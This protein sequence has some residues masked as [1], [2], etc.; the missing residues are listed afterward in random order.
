[1]SFLALV[2]LFTL[3]IFKI[4]LGTPNLVHLSSTAIKTIIY[5]KTWQKSSLGPFSVKKA[6]IS[7]FGL[8]R[9]ENAQNA[10]KNENN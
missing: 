4:E 10:P 3:K 1:M 2:G 6:F 7:T 8:F 9:S 5:E